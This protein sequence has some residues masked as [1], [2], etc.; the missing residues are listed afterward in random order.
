MIEVAKERTP[1]YVRPT[2]NAILAEMATLGFIGLI[3]NADALGLQKGAIAGLSQ[4][5]LGEADLGFELFESVHVNLFQTAV[6]YFLTCGLLVAG[7]VWRLE[8]IFESIDT[9]DDGIIT[10]AEFVAAKPK[11]DQIGDPAL[12]D[13]LL[14]R[15]VDRVLDPQLER[16][17]A[18]G[19]VTV[20][21]VQEVAA[22]RLEELV[23]IDPLT[24]F[25][26]SAPFGLPSL[27]LQ[28]TSKQPIHGAPGDFADLASF[29]EVASAG[30]VAASFVCFDA[31]FIALGDQLVP[32]RFVLKTIKVLAFICSFAFAS[33]APAFVS[34]LGV[35]LDGAASPVVLTEL[36]GVGICLLALIFVLVTIDGVLFEYIG[37]ATAARLPETSTENEW[38]N[39][40]A[41]K[42]L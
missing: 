6:S 32:K 8:A 19:G 11:L 37:A 38:S 24:I 10:A 40:G 16:A 42:N 2:I 14:A 1:K 17:R 23:E 36:S 9:N 13:T 4:Q 15:E 18:Q 41:R 3:V 29:V 31:R 30:V 20:A 35:V 33:S 34:D 28:I 12:F 26:I 21:D 7:V 39:K 27:V 25:L 22:E 5:F